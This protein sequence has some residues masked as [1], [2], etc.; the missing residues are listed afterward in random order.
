MNE[1]R[2]RAGGREGGGQLGGDVAALAHPG[3]DEP[4][5]SQL[6]NKRDRAQERLPQPR[7]QSG[8]PGGLHLQDA[9]GIGERRA[10]M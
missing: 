6:G 7:A 8:K 3:D 10:V 5:R 2:R 1:E 4:P 9:A